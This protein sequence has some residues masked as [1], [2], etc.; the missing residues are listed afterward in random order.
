MCPVVCSMSSL[1]QSLKD[2]RISQKVEWRREVEECM[3]VQPHEEE[4]AKCQKRLDELIVP[5]PACSMNLSKIPFLSTVSYSDSDDEQP[6]SILRKKSSVEPPPFNKVHAV[7]FVPTP[8]RQ[9]GVSSGSKMKTPPHNAVVAARASRSRSPMKR[10]PRQRSIRF[11]AEVKISYHI[12]HGKMTKTPPRDSIHAA[13]QQG[14]DPFALL[15][16]SYM[17]QFR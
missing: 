4:Y 10:Q 16:E 6:Q 13:R 8:N 12:P 15:P 2:A 5:S 14:V 7:K 11:A 3:G 9:R 17:D 1:S